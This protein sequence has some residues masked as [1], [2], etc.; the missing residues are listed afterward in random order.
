MSQTNYARLE[1]YEKLIWA[2]DAWKVARDN[3]LLMSLVGE[4]SGAMVQRV[5]EMTKT[6]KGAKAIITLV[7]DLTGD[8]V[9]GDRQLKGNEDTQALNQIEI[10]V[11]QL[12]NAEINEGRMADQKSVVNFR[13]V[14]RDALGYWLANMLD[15]LMF[16]TLA[17]VAY[18]YKNSGVARVGSDLPYLDYAGLVTPPTA[19]RLLTW[20]ATGFGVNADNTAITA[21]DTPTWK[22]LVEAKAYAKEQ[23]IKPL[24]GGKGMEAYNVF[25]TPTAMAKLK[26]DTD[27]LAAWRSAMPRD[28]NNPLFKGAEV[29]YIDGLAIREDRRVFHSSTWGSGA[30]KGCRTLLC[31]AQALGFG[32]LGD[33][34]W[35]EEGEDYENRQGISVGKVFGFRKPK[36]KSKVTGIEE[37]FGVLCLDHAQ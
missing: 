32:D 31:G 26:L 29:I 11:D 21:A 16:L 18:S 23:Y 33:P 25:M 6:E 24:K 17:G 22:M 10:V 37:D 2:K 14:A 12:R 35:V 8:G 4:D 30:V 7:H 36:F 13:K 19:G 9:A 3:A 15:Q 34:Y 27:F 20:D 28:P 5:T 1:T